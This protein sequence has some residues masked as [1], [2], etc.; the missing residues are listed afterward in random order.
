MKIRKKPKALT[1]KDKS[2]AMPDSRL[3]EVLD[4]H[5]EEVSTWRIFKIL[6]EFVSGFDFLRKY[7][8][9]SISIFGT[10]R[11]T[12]ED[13]IYKQ[14][15]LL[16]NKLARDGFA[17]ITGGGPGIME[18]ANRGAHEAGGQSVGL[19]IQL[20]TEQR[21]NKYV[22]ESQAFEYFFTRKVMLSFASI[23]YVFF[24]GGYGT[25]D[26]LFEM[27]TLIQTEKI[28]PIPV[29]L[30][31]KDFWG[32]L[33]SWLTETVL[34]KHHAIGSEDLEIFKV[35]EDADEAYRYIKSLKIKI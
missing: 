28:E 6:S 30:I 13:S 12:F 27:I 19:N 3:Q 16:G 4:L 35:V 10:A 17:I 15:A 5:K 18:A 11:C 14:A 33:V 24:P 9:R 34:K 32:P 7:R 8:G 22:T 25:L 20:P 23:V 2:A 26:E 1:E 31:G 21:I 29:V